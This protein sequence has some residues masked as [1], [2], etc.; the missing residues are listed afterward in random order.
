[1][2]T[3]AAADLS[4]TQDGLQACSEH[5]GWSVRLNGEVWCYLFSV[6]FEVWSGKHVT[7]PI[8]F[9]SPK[10]SI[11]SRHSS[12]GVVTGQSKDCTSIFCRCK[13]G[14]PSR[15]VQTGCEA[16]PA[17]FSPVWGFLKAAGT[18]IW[19]LSEWMELYLQCSI[20]ITWTL[21]V[22]FVKTFRFEVSL[23]KYKRLMWTPGSSVRLSI[24]TLGVGFPC[25][26][27]W[28]NDN[29]L[30]ESWYLLYTFL[31]DLGEIRYIGPAGRSVE[32]FVNLCQL[33][34]VSLPCGGG[35]HRYM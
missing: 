23:S 25:E 4:V 28:P 6:K 14:F 30:K 7:A 15:I 9:R 8:L 1:M 12:V 24:R 21:F 13:R 31:T 33:L 32:Q 34:W 20:W 2:H 35:R 11:R 26:S 19:P 17:S 18:W 16:R 27:H 3:I 22:A 5:V 10:C 29:Y